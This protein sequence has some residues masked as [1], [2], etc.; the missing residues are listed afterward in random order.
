VP[1]GDQ[2]LRL[3][4]ECLL[5][6]ILREFIDGKASQPEDGSDLD[7]HLLRIIGDKAN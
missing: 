2:F 5:V 3:R 1:K 4:T 6:R 7:I